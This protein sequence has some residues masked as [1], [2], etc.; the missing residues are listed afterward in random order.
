M[1]PGCIKCFIEQANKLFVKYGVNED[2]ARDIVVRLRLFIEDHENTITTPEIS[3]LLHRMIKNVTQTEDLFKKE[4]KEF[5]SLLLS[6]EEE[7]KN[8]IDQ[9][10]DPF[11]A[12]LRYALAGNVIDFGAPHTF[13][14]FKELS[15]ASSHQPAIDHSERLKTALEQAKTVLYLGDNAGEIVL[16]KI[17][18]EIINHP[19]L[20]YAVRGGNIIND[21]TL[22]DADVVG[23]HKVSK[24]ISNGYDAPSTLLNRCSKEFRKIFNRADVIISKGQGNLEGLIEMQDKSIFFLLMVKCEIIAQRLNVREKSTIVFHNQE[25]LKNK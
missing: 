24:V 25:L 15:A 7:L 1:H 6:L 23:I 19:D 13:D 2:D 5:N 4:K 12:A 18:I 8:S 16:D 14:V 11:Q 10:N 22:E 9:S 17:F 3:C 20:Y 21:V